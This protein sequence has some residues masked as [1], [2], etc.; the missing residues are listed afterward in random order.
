MD[1]QDRDLLIR[2][3]ANLSTLTSSFTELKT[4]TKTLQTENAKEHKEIRQCISG[5]SDRFL[6]R[7]TFWKIVGLLTSLGVVGVAVKL[8]I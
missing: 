4:D 3:D 8:L 1:Q 7:S 5:Q 6:L 2:M